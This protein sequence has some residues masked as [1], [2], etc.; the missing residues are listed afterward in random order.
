[1]DIKVINHD[2]NKFSNQK[3]RLKL[4]N[5]AL[6]KN[7]NLFPVK[8]YSFF[9]RIAQFIFGCKSISQHNLECSLKYANSLLSEKNT[10]L[11]TNDI[12]DADLEIKN[13][14][15]TFKGYLN[16]NKGK[17]DK[18]RLEDLKYKLSNLDNKLGINKEDQ[19]KLNLENVNNK[20]NVD[21]LVKEELS[22][23]KE[24]NGNDVL[25]N[26]THDYS[27]TNIE[28]SVSNKENNTSNITTVTTNIHEDIEIAQTIS[29]EFIH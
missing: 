5:N 13:I 10:N 19:L 20:F 15:N 7:K 3:I 18:K 17:N 22:D 24:T 6:K 28:A 21:M 12:S 14:E 11:A 8:V 27:G 26:L 2:I 9:S 25:F 29:T 16:T 4:E 23:E 1:M